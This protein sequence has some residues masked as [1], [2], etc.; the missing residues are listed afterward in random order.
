[1]YETIY[2]ILVQIESILNSRPLY[3]LSNDHNDLQALIAGHFLIGEALIALPQ[4]KALPSANKLNHYHLLQAQLKISGGG[5]P[6][7]I[8]TPCNRDI[9]GCWMQR[10]EFK[11]T[12]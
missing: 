8:Y 5:G 6:L 11:C 4:R 2:T 7:N 3:P 1:M 9:S 10:K 12:F